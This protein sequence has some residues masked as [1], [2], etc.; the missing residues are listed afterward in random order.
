MN[1]NNR[2]A[3]SGMIIVTKE[4]CL[5]C[6]HIASM[7]K[8]SVHILNKVVLIKGCFFI[9]GVIEAHLLEA[10]GVAFDTTISKQIFW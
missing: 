5:I 6:H 2:S 1:W 3:E 9:G 4:L 8:T 10:K 7:S